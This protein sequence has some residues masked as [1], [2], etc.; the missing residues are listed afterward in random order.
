MKDILRRVANIIKLRPSVPVSEQFCAQ[1]VT[2]PSPEAI[3]VLRRKIKL[4]Y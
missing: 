3:C 1:C 4:S 2:C